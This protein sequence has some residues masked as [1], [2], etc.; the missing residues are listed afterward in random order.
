[1]ASLNKSQF[2]RNTIGISLQCEICGS[3]NITQNEAGYVCKECGIMLDL[4]ILEYHRP[5]NQDI[6]QYD[7]LGKTQIGFT[8]E[9]MQNPQSYQ[10]SRLNRLDSIK[11]NEENVKIRAMIEMNRIFEALSLP[12]SDKKNV[13][14]NFVQIRSKIGHGT[15]YRSPEK[16]I[17][18]VIYFTY[19]FDCKPIDEKTLLEV[20]NIDKKDFQSFKLQIYDFKPEYKERNRME[21][22][23]QKVLEITEHFELGMYFF[24]QS[25]KILDKL[26]DIIKNTKD[27][28]IAGVVTSISALC[29]PKKLISVSEICRKLNIRMSTIHKQVERKI[30]ERFRVLGFVSLVKSAE[31]LKEVMLKIGVIME[32]HI[33]K[34]EE[35]AEYNEIIEI[36]LGN[37][38]QIFNA[39]ETFEYYFY[40]F[41]ELHNKPILLSLV[42]DK[43][44][45]R[46]LFENKKSSEKVP[47]PDTGR[48]QLFNLAIWRVKGPPL[49]IL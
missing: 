42:I 10:L 9:R 4:Q 28:V 30:F 6:I 5:Y 47:D 3:E 12:E 15:K 46:D 20:S 1:M 29:L 22:V 13:F 18:I 48:A 33:E 36:E 7:P 25:K 27:N 44:V 37:G 17:P 32:E 40:A 8:K 23:C 2:S 19:K 39:F 34:I 43:M 26:W 16:L 21:Y 38:M 35:E 49:I 45:I 31:L 41:R 24:Y 11:S 14:S